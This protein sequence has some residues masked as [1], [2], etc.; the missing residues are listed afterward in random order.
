MRLVAGSERLVLWGWSLN[1]VFSVLASVAA[2]YSA[3]HIGTG[4]TFMAAAAAYL[5]AG[6]MLQIL[7]RHP[8]TDAGSQ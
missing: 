8:M 2:I 3:I 1:G 4:R 7:R 6:A 5:L